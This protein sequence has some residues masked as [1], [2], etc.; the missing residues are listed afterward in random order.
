MHLGQG[1]PD[2]PSGERGG[3]EKAGGDEDGGGEEGTVDGL[4]PGTWLGK[5]RPMPW[6][7]EENNIKYFPKH[8]LYL[9]LS[10]N[11]LNISIYIIS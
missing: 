1:G 7:V 11:P 3:K 2:H 6:T 8:T 9:N 5:E 10:K 4:S